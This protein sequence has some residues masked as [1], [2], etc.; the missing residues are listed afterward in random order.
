MFIN[1]YRLWRLEI[2]NRIIK[3]VVNEQQTVWIPH[4]SEENTIQ[5]NTWNES[6]PRAYFTNLQVLQLQ[7]YSTFWIMDSTGT[8]DSTN[9]NMFYTC[10]ITR[11]VLREI[12]PR[13]D[14]S[15]KSRLMV[16]LGFAK[17]KST[18]SR[19]SPVPFTCLI[20][21]A[22]FSCLPNTPRISA[23]LLSECVWRVYGVTTL[24]VPDR[25]DWSRAN[26]HSSH[27][28]SVQD[29]HSR[30]FSTLTTLKPW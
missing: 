26:K 27:V 10:V 8:R 2:F 1:L 18:L 5:L 25:Y 23:S 29:A 14:K 3:L 24:R 16:K 15:P 22:L 28:W 12:D 9:Q 11:L 13:L 19:L 30:C 4:T 7:V 6:T 21:L 20:E 17:W